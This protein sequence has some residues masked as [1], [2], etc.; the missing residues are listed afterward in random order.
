MRMD[1]GVDAWNYKP[2]SLDTVMEHAR[3]FEGWKY[4]GPL[5]DPRQKKYDD[6][7]DL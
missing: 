3:M 7:E 6:R 5:E 2:V 4:E 1:V